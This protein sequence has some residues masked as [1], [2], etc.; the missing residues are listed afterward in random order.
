MSVLAAL[1]ILFVRCCVF[2]TGSS[3]GGAVV[4][5]FSMTVAVTEVVNTVVVLFVLFTGGCGSD[6]DTVLCL[7]KNKVLVWLLCDFTIK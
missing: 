2:V 3:I 5:S 6:G 1:C 7:V 4:T